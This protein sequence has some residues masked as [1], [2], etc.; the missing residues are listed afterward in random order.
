MTVAPAGDV[1]VFERFGRDLQDALFAGDAR[2][3]DRRSRRRSYR[4]S[5]SPLEVA[6]GG[7]FEG[8]LDRDRFAGREHLARFGCAGDAENGAAGWTTPSIVSGAPPT[9]RKVAAAE[10]LPPTVVPPNDSTV[11]EASTFASAGCP[12]PCSE[13]LIVPCAGFDGQR[14]GLQARCRSV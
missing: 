3:R 6:F 12:V 10:S 1:A 2:K 9:L 5:S 13:K 8:D 7:G 11:G 4:A 14:R